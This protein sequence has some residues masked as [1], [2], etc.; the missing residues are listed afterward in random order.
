LILVGLYFWEA[1]RR[2]PPGTLLVRKDGRHRFLWRGWMLD[3]PFDAAGFSLEFNPPSSAQ[4]PK[5]LAKK[6]AFFLAKAARRRHA[7]IL[8]VYLL[9]LIVGAF[10]AGEPWPFLLWLPAAIHFARAEGRRLKALADAPLE[11]L[12]SRQIAWVAFPLE[13]FFEKGLY[14]H[15]VAQGVDPLTQIRPNQLS[16]P[17]LLAYLRSRLHDRQTLQK[18]LGKQS[19][20]ALLRPE[21][22]KPDT[23]AYCPA[24]GAEYAQARSTC[25]DCPD[26]PLISI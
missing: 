8:F 26:A 14:S 2:V 24:C 15:A 21:R 19:L 18:W 11:D 20:D 10:V 6:E 17:E 5:L 9:L 16:R 23:V 7:L 4:P 22:P 25:Q 1:L 12:L 13:I 3:H